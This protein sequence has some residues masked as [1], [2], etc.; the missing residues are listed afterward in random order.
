MAVLT[1][2]AACCIAYLIG[3]I[4]FAVVS[5]RLF[6]LADPRTYGSGNPGATNV[7]RTGH[8][9]AALFTL[10]GDTCKGAFAVLMARFLGL[11]ESSIAVFGDPETAVGLAGLA[12]Y[13]GHL[14][15][16]FLRF[17][18]GKGV[19]TA[20]GV[21][22][23]FT[24]LAGL[25]ALG[26]WILAAAAT[27]YSSLASIIAGIAALA[28]APLRRFRAFSH[29]RGHH[30]RGP[31]PQTPGQHQAPDRGRRNQDRRQEGVGRE[32]EN[33]KPCPAVQGGKIFDAVRFFP[34]HGRIRKE[35]GLLAEHLLCRIPQ[36]FLHPP[37]SNPLECDAYSKGKHTNEQIIRSSQFAVLRGNQTRFN[38]NSA[39]ISLSRRT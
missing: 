1:C 38:G 23:A 31:H 25:A 5:A 24:P 15:P 4:A 3:S 20:G 6:H 36:L 14:Y 19:A 18:G 12:A 2:L 8:K 37:G 17:K 11:G 26:S 30:G 22:L 21:M 27:R 28:G 7:L 10:L 9:K 13:A 29:H 35:A 39:F 34:G 16:L 33:R 32:A